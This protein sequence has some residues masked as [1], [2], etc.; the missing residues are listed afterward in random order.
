MIKK[1]FWLGDIIHESRVKT[2]TCI[3]PLKA[4][5]NFSA[6]KVAT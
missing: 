4:L 3:R 6:V 5:P 2:E 1:V